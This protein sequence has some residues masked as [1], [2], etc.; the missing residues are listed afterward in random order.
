M[1]CY[2]SNQIKKQTKHSWS[3]PAVDLLRRDLYDFLAAPGAVVLLEKSVDG[4]L[5]GAAHVALAA[6]GVVEEPDLERGR[7]LEA[8]V[9]R[10]LQGAVI[11]RV[12]V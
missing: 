1:F 9:Y 8:Q 7:T 6:L 11:P 3:H 2:A 10:L 12:K 4:R 5:D